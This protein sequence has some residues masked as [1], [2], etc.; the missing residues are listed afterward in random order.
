MSGWQCQDFTHLSDPKAATKYSSQATSPPTAACCLPLPRQGVTCPVLSSPQQLTS[1]LSYSLSL[2]GRESS[3]EV[4]THVG[5]SR[6]QAA[7]R[8]RPGNNTGPHIQPVTECLRRARPGGR[9]VA[10]APPPSQKGAAETRAEKVA[11]SLGAILEGDLGGKGTARP[12]HTLSAHHS[13]AASRRQ[14]HTGLGDPARQHP[15]VRG[16]GRLLCA[17]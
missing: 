8:P 13:P 16:P 17:G 7:P 5:S 4:Q 9:A 3:S 10:P 15:P 1:R 2:A 12:A 14:R 6:P 11:G